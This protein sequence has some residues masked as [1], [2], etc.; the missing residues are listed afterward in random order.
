MKTKYFIILLIVSIPFFNSCEDV[1]D[2]DIDNSNQQIVI[3]AAITDTE[4]PHYVKISKTG[5][6]FKSQEFEKINNALAIISDNKGTFD[7]LSEVSAGTYATSKIV[8][9]EGMD[10]QLLVK[11]EGK[12]Y[13]ASTTMPQKVELDSLEYHWQESMTPHGNDGYFVKGYFSDSPEMKNYYRFRINLN[14]EFYLEA[15]NEIVLW[16]DKL[17]E[18]EKDV[19]I[20]IKRGGDFFQ[21]NDL[22]E[23]QLISLNKEMYEYYQSLISA[24]SSVSGD[25]MM[26]MGKSM[27]FGSSAPSNPDNNINNEALRYFTAYTVSS[28]TISLK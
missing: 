8:G 14:G 9:V 17:F 23:V 20:P 28:K 2:I 12:E 10:Y 5:D 26:N 13:T 16:D 6:Y 21:E 7:T 18:G 15:T 25:G 19:N 4:G 22:V 24:I 3:E 27:I 11:I 1:I